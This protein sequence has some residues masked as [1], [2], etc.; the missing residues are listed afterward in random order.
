MKP[1]PYLG[2]FTLSEGAAWWIMYGDEWPTLQAAAVKILSQP[3]AS[4]ASERYFSAA[5]FARGNGS[6]SKQGVETTR[7]L[8]R[9]RQALRQQAQELMARELKNI[10]TVEGLEQR[11]PD[12]KPSEEELELCRLA[13]ASSSSAFAGSASAGSAQPVPNPFA[14]NVAQPPVAVVVAD[15]DEE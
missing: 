15:N 9:V 2:K 10:Y 8:V 12:Y 14:L 5:K 7:K 3:V 4:S 6:R 13:S 1:S 11:D